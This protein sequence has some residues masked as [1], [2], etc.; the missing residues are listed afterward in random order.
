MCITVYY[1]TLHIHIHIHYT[2]HNSTKWPLVS[3]SCYAF[4]GCRS[5]FTAEEFF[6]ILFLVRFLSVRL[7][8][9]QKINKTKQ[10]SC[11]MLDE[12]VYVGPLQKGKLLHKNL[13]EC[14]KYQKLKVQIWS[15]WV[16]KAPACQR[17]WWEN[18]L[19]SWHWFCHGL[20][21]FQPTVEGIWPKSMLN[22]EGFWAIIL[23]LG[24]MSEPLTT[25]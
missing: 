20:G 7:K 16:P 21:A 12:M 9:D 4:R 14:Y 24:K 2:V 6:Y 17:S 1:S 8:S 18:T 23:Y 22:S 19:M 3:M 13:K 15:F 11:Q 5:Q 10:Q 25:S